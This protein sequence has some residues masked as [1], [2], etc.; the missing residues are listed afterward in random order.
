[1]FGILK[2]SWDVIVSCVDSIAAKREERE[3]QLQ[4]EE[5]NELSQ[6]IDKLH[7]AT[8]LQEL[9]KINNLLQKPHCINYLTSY[10]SPKNRNALEY[11]CI[12]ATEQDYQQLLECILYVSPRLTNSSK[13]LISALNHQNAKC[14][15]KIIENSQHADWILLQAKWECEN[16]H[17]SFEFTITSKLLKDNLES[18]PALA[19][20]KH[21]PSEAC[22]V[23]FMK[24]LQEEIKDRG[25]FDY[26]ATRDA[27]AILTAAKNWDLEKCEEIIGNQKSL[28]REEQ[29][30]LS[31]ILGY[32]VF[33]PH[34][35]SAGKVGYVATSLSDQSHQ[36][37]SDDTKKSLN[38]T[39]ECFPLTYWQKTTLQRIVAPPNKIP[40]LLGWHSENN[41]NN[42]P[43]LGDAARVDED[44]FPIYDDLLAEVD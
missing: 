35:K 11:I 7:K 12:K 19:A 36:E 30:S 42:K 4:G 43:L 1:M 32:Y 44:T 33:S 22:L 18:L 6:M 25:L 24:D 28:S 13:I 26:G 29:E 40:L 14:I 17:N 27:I 31:S 20:H 34:I 41:E 3:K 15:Q 39:T 16:N 9:Q 8:E 10:W 2:N 21:F 23:Q 38:Q 5:I 37:Q